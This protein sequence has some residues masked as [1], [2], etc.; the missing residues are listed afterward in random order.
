MKRT[1]SLKRETLAELTGP[2]LESVAGALL[3]GPSLDRSCPT[4]PVFNCASVNACTTV[5]PCTVTF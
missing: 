1:L 4:V 5:F 2:E 3:S